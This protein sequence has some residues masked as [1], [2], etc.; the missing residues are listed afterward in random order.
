MNSHYTCG[1]C[2]LVLPATEHNFFASGLKRVAKDA[3]RLVIPQCKTCA[4]QYATE[5]RSAIKLKGLTRSQKT[6]SMAAGAKRGTIYVIGASVPGTPYKIGVTAGSDT[7][8][9]LSS[10]QVGNWMVLKE[11]W[12]SPVLERAGVIESQLHQHFDHCRVR[13]EWFNI[14]QDDIDA[15]GTLIQQLEL[16][17]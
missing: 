8:K 7:R 11:V 12:K 6:T 14:T 10:N 16:V 13:G 9:R 3:N 17:P 4:K 5:W 2:K 15:M 1:K